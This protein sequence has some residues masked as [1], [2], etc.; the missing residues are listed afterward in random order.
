M[1]ER[2][3]STLA[4]IEERVL[5]CEVCYQRIKAPKMLSC[6]HTFCASCC[7]TITV[8]IAA[9]QGNEGGGGG[10]GGG[11]G[12]GGG[13][14]GSR[15]GPAKIT[16][17]TCQASS[18]LPEGGVS[19]LRTNKTLLKLLEALDADQP[20][21]YSQDT[22]ALIAARREIAENLGRLAASEGSSS[23]CV[24]QMY[25]SVFSELEKRRDS[26]LQEIASVATAQRQRLMSQD[27]EL[28]RTLELLSRSEAPAEGL[29]NLLGNIRTNRNGSLQPVASYITFQPPAEPLLHAICSWGR[30]HV[31]G[32]TDTDTDKPEVT[33]TGNH[34]R[35]SLVMEERG[36]KGGGGREREKGAGDGG[37]EGEEWRDG[38][39]VEEGTVVKMLYDDGVWY[40]GWVEKVNQSTGM[41]VVAFPDGIYIYIHSQTS[42]I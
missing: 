40:K 35:Q 18:V 36:G 9:D 13:G 41:Y 6:D 33:E 39:E 3:T 2:H 26:A 34:A 37:I 11:G 20:L 29:Q 21:A 23:V 15:Q 19:D 5:L 25:A 14:G 24:I 10:G 32:D 31:G 38:D 28:A 4:K 7:K 12:A 16:C 27:A 8:R 1:T 17:P 42:S 22:A 30:V